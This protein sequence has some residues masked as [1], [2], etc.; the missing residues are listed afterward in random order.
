MGEAKTGPDRRLTL[1][2]PG[3]IVCSALTVH[4]HKK[5]RQGGSN[6]F[7]HFQET[8]FLEG[9]TLHVQYFIT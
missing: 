1:L 3:D 9:L 4:Y 2:Q 5:W 7:Q 8:L 6:G